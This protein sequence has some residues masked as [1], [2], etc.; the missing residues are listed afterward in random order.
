MD[1]KQLYA[2]LS[3]SHISLQQHTRTSPLSCYEAPRRHVGGLV[4]CSAHQ[5]AGDARERTDVPHA[6]RLAFKLAPPTHR[7][8]KRRQTT[9]L[10]I[11]RYRYKRLNSTGTDTESI[12][13]TSLLGCLY[14]EV[15]CANRLTG[16]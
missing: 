9:R 6:P 5:Y 8:A 7:V 3:L 13:I 12:L 10:L 16:L 11:N 15:S 14:Y 1:N 4:P 2:P